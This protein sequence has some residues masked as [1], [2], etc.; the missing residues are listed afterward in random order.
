RDTPLLIIVGILATIVGC[1][2]LGPA[3]IRIFSGFAG[4]VPIAPRLALRDLVRY[5]ARSGAA[6]AAVALAL[7]IAATVV[8]VASAEAAKRNAEPV[9]LSDRQARVYLGRPNTRES[10]PGGAVSQI[11]R[12]SGSAHQIAD[13]LGHADVV[14]LTKV[15]QPSTPAFFDPEAGYKVMPTVELTV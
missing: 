5:Q 4:R 14:P 11:P 3:A 1:L 7:G 10:L 2:L 6:L 8:L 15:F 13:R 12:L 9:N